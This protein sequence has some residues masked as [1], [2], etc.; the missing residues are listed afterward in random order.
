[1]DKELIAREIE[2]E[3]GQFYDWNDGGGAC[4][5]WAI[6]ALRVLR[7]HNVDAILQAGTCLW[8]RVRAEDDDGVMNTHFGYE[9]HA[10]SER[11]V[12]MLRMG[13]LP[14]MHIWVA[15]PS[16]NEILDFS[17][18]FLPEQCRL[19]IGEDWPGDTPPNYLWSRA[20]ELPERVVYAPDAGAC[21]IAYKRVCQFM[22]M[23]RKERVWVNCR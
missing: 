14:E 15:I 23:V 16:R 18:R 21:F 22:R 9:Y 3:F 13:A 17:T 4:L 8:P 7:L 20:E 1:M 6:A 19:I 12:E 5:L 11:T 2:E 10:D